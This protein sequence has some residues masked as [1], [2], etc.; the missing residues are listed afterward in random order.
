MIQSVA[1]SVS[2]LESAF[3]ARES[4]LRTLELEQAG[5]AALRTALAGNGPDSLA[6]R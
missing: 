3:S 6:A 2:A 4:A 5:I 1:R